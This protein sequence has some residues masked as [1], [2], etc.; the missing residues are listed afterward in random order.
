MLHW[1]KII[2]SKLYV[3]HHSNEA[4]VATFY[5][6]LP[7]FSLHSLFLHAP[8]VNYAVGEG[9]HGTTWSGSDVQFT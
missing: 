2:I 5:K 6:A 7:T 9:V 3:W 1:K 8:V 4:D